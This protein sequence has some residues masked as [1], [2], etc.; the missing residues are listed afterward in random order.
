MT[1]KRSTLFS[2]ASPLWKPH[3]FSQIEELID[4]NDDLAVIFSFNSINSS[5]YFEAYTLVPL[6]SP[7]VLSRIYL[8]ACNFPDSICNTFSR[9]DTP[10]TAS[11]DLLPFVNL[12]LSQKKKYKPVAKRTRPVIAKLLDKFRIVRKINSDP[13]ADFPIPP[14]IFDEVCAII[15]KKLAAGIYEPSNLSY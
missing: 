14:S 1:S 3:G 15:R 7:S 4:H 12:F 9:Q 6:F 11:Q 2:W 5:L 8:S 13:L 10:S